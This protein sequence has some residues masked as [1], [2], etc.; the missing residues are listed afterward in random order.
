MDCPAS[1]DRWV[2]WMVASLLSN[3]QSRYMQCVK[4]EELKVGDWYHNNYI[5]FIK[6]FPHG[7]SYKIYSSL[8]PCLQFTLKWGNRIFRDG[9]YLLVDNPTTKRFFGLHIFFLWF[10]RF[11]LVALT[12]YKPVKDEIWILW[13]SINHLVAGLSTI[14]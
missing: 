11:N 3:I 12:E 5:W 1:Y 4:A 8:P 14:S 13:S 6:K 7:E 2:I 10:N 9:S